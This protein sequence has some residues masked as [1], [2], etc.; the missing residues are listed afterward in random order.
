ML[1]GLVGKPHSGKSEVRF[2]LEN[3]G[4]QAINTKSS[5]AMACHELTGVPVAQFQTQEGKETLYKGIPLRQ[6]MGRVQDSL[7][8]MFGD[9]HT[10]EVALEKYDIWGETNLVLDS[11]RKT[12]PRQWPG[13]IVEVCSHHSLDTG[14]PFDYYDD[15]T[16]DYRLMNSGSLGD[17]EANIK[18]MLDYFGV[19]L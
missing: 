13:K 1:I 4:F 11:L 19:R 16:V 3:L 6:V 2:I 14:N 10:I 9:Y 18:V 7:E 8:A 15:S 12:Q 5:L 17:L